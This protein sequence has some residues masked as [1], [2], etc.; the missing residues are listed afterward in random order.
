MLKYSRWP[1][2]EFCLTQQ[3]EFH[4]LKDLTDQTKWRGGMFKFKLRVPRHAINEYLR[5]GYCVTIQWTNSG[6]K[7]G[8]VWDLTNK[9]RGMSLSL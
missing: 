2:R 9:H 3:A 5:A 4:C 7:S 8:Q 6:C 1:K